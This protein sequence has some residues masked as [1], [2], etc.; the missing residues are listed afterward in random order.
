MQEYLLPARQ[1]VWMKITALDGPINRST[2]LELWFG[3][4]PNSTSGKIQFADLTL[5]PGESVVFEI[6]TFKYG[7]IIFIEEVII[8]TGYHVS[9]SLFK[10]SN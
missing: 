4:K 10:I 7:P 5:N 1:Q 6:N 8:G 2:N 9:H 3:T